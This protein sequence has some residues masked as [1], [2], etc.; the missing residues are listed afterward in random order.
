M[1]GESAHVQ[2]YSNVVTPFNPED[3]SLSPQTPEEIQ[4]AMKSKYGMLHLL[5]NLSPSGRNLTCKDANQ[6]VPNYFLRTILLI[7]R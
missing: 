5:P 2:T 6:V 7:L 1:N 4:S 3:V